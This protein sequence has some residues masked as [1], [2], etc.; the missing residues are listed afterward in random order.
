VTN[1]PRLARPGRIEDDAAEIYRLEALVLEGQHITIY[2]A[3]R[4]VRAMVHPA[5]EGLD[6]IILELADALFA[7]AIDSR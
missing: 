1:V 7:A 5:I 4:A 6:D 2:S 3:E